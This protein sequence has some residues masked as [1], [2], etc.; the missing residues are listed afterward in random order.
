VLGLNPEKHPTISEVNRAYRKTAL[1]VHPDK[2]GDLIEVI[3]KK[4]ISLWL[5]CYFICECYI[6]LILYFVKQK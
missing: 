6:K 2:G 5:L 1:K 3:L 4:N